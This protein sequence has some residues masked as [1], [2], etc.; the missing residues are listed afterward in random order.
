MKVQILRRNKTQL[1][2]DVYEYNKYRAI[3]AWKFSTL[4]FS[5]KDLFD[6]EMRMAR[7][8]WNTLYASLYKTFTEGFHI[9]II[10]TCW[11]LNAVIIHMVF[12]A[13]WSSIGSNEIT[14]PSR[15]L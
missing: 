3:F 8:K 12:Q 9:I 13:N 10:D 7:L 5:L 15:N 6:V 2:D 14:V 4:R 11:I 1:K